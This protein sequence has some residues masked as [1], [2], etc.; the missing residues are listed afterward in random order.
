MK[1]EVNEEINRL[2]I[3]DDPYLSSDSFNLIATQVMNSLLSVSSGWQ[4]YS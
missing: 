4:V 3:R 1:E 2:R